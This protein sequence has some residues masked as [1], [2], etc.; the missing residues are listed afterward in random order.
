MAFPEFFNDVP[1]L[2]LR[3]PLAQLLGAAPDGVM[4]YR[5]DDAV[6]LAGHSCP[7]VAGAWLSAR[8]GLR[9][10]YGDELPERGAISVSMPDAEDAGVTG[11]IAQVMTLITG[12]AGA[13]GF[14]GLGG[15]YARCHLLQ[16]SETNVRGVRL[17]RNDTRTAVEVELDTRRVPADPRQQQLI[18]LVVQ[19][20]ADAAQR[21]EFGNVWQQRVRRL[22][23]EHADDPAVIR[24]KSVR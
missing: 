3:D 4:E 1:S 11:V 18:G 16:F 13:S 20:R 7:T 10:L 19:G 8:A 12:A 2:R 9:S 6:R 14:K 17:R 24:V 22:L 23:L 15:Q 5:Y 21:V